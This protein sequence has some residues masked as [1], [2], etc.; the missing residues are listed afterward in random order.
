MQ[1]NTALAKNVYGI[2][3]LQYA[4]GVVPYLNVIT[5]ESNLI[6][7]QIGYLNALYSVLSSKI[8][9]QKS[10]GFININH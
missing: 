4:Q 3:T 10:M 9:L 2:V 8:D 7:S 1:D 5:A 6:N